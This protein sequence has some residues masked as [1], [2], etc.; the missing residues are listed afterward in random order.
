MP[1]GAHLGIKGGLANAVAESRRLDTDALQVFT[2]S[3]QMWRAKPVEE[4]A[5]Q[6]FRTARATGPLAVVVHDSYLINL[7]AAG[8]ELREKSRVALADELDRCALYGI[9]LVNSHMGS[10]VGQGEAEGI[11]L[12]SCAVEPLLA[13]SDPSI[14]LLMET[15]AGAGSALGGTFEGL[16]RALD[17]LNGDPRVGVC[18]DTC[19]VFAA[20][21]DL[22]TPEAVAETLGKFDEVIGLDRLRAVH[23]NDSK[24]AFGSHKD[25]HANLGEG[26][27]GLE[28]LKAFVTNPRLAHVPMILE[29]PQEG[30]GHVR[31]LEL[32]RAWRG[33][34]T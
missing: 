29:T 33:A 17:A 10:H 34:T 31:D 18:L 4:S 7:C 26:E 21:Y 20:G 2:S 12:V 24:G 14:T 30:D 23:L 32:I 19:H 3:P 25:R 13:N 27:I 16:A 8:E 9:E 28:G 22:R 6:A 15:T 11:R 1:I 5:A